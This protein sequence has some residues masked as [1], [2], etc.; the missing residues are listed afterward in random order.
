[1]IITA[2]AL[3]SGITAEPLTY[4]ICPAGYGRVVVAC[5]SGDG[6][7]FSTVATFGAFAPTVSCSSTFGNCQ[8]AC[9]AALGSSPVFR[10]LDKNTM[11]SSHHVTA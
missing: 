4:C 11:W 1:M 8:A 9:I 10:W 3:A 5:H 7:I 6:F 2:L